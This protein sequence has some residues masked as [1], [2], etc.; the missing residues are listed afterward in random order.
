M[1]CKKLPTESDQNLEEDG[2][3]GIIY[4]RQN[5]LDSSIYYYERAAKNGKK[6]PSFYL[7]NQ[8]NL[9]GAIRKQGNIQKALTML[10][11]IKEAFK[12]NSEERDYQYYKLLIAEYY[13]ELNNWERAQEYLD[14]IDTSVILKKSQFKKT[15]GQVG[16]TLQLKKQNYKEALR[17]YTLYRDAIDSME[18]ARIDSNFKEIESKY[19]LSQKQATIGKQKLKIKHHA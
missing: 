8:V 11:D 15:Y 13:T 3:L 4:E 1:Q 14:G 17:F 16:H 5:R 6:Y 9:A 2:N 12:E 19:D 10:L 18:N 7:Q